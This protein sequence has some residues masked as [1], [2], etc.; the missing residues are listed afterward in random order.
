MPNREVFRSLLAFLEKHERHIGVFA[1][2]A[3]FATDSFTLVRPD[4]FWGNVLLLSYFLISALGIIYLAV[5]DRREKVTP[6]LL[7]GLVQF[8]FGNLAS[9]LMVLYGRSGTLEGSL[10]FFML[11]TGFFIGNEFLRNYYSKINF[12]ISAWYF[13]FLAYL[14][15]VVP[16]VIGK[17]GDGVFILSTLVSLIIVGFFLYL[18][19]VISKRRV[20]RAIKEII[21]SV[22]TIFVLFNLFYFLNIIPPVPL[23]LRDIG[24][25]H[26]LERLDNGDYKVLYE[27]PDWFE[28]FRSTS[29]RYT[30]IPGEKVYCFSSV[31]APVG[32]G[33]GVYHRFEYYNE[34]AGKWQTK[35]LV[36]FRIA[37]GRDNGYRGYSEKS[38]IDFGLWRCSV[39]TKRGALI[40]RTTFRVV[41]NESTLYEKVL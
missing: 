17:L 26:S 21:F 7:V 27:K 15:L 23:S 24:I 2:I 20:V 34:T 38:G 39:E 9:G 29:K 25:Y 3:G 22:I 13:L 30:F 6:I 32:I 10:P 8:V 33:T 16:I 28:F 36:N 18:I 35:L 5:Y 37:G 4:Q 12:H 11:F 41:E 14:V 40:G 19:Y 1:M 31:Y